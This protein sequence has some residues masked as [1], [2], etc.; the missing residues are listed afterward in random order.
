MIFYFLNS[1]EFYVKFQNNLFGSQYS[2]KGVYQ[3]GILSPLL[4]ILY[5][6]KLNNILGNEISNLQY[7]DDLTVYCAGKNMQLVEQKLNCALIKLKTYFDY[8]K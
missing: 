6:H 7:A 3:G 4:F 5:I 8:L 1:R 2:N